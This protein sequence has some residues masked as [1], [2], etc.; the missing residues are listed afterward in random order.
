M[1][2]NFTLR[3]A[4][5]DNGYVLQI[6]GRGTMRESKPA[7]AFVDRAMADA[8]SAVVLDLAACDY[9]DST[10][11]GC[12]LGLHRRHGPGRVRVTAPADR[13]KKLF[14]PTR[15]DALLRVSS[16]VP[17]VI[18]NWIVISPDSMESTDMARHMMECHRLLAE[19]PGPQQSAFAAIARQLEAEL[20][21]GQA[22]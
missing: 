14:G 11:L 17:E 9:L 7:E 6:G 22:K 19:I 10:F 12:L 3:F 20:A 8:A 5:F 1:A 13:V 21:A 18:G 16:S 15:V 4:R 2:I